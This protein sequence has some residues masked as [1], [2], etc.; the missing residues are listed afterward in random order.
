MRR[1]TEEMSESGIW[2]PATNGSWRLL[3]LSVL[4]SPVIVHAKVM[5]VSSTRQGEEKRPEAGSWQREETIHVNSTPQFARDTRKHFRVW[6]KRSSRFAARTVLCHFARWSSSQTHFMS[7]AQCTWLHRI[8]LPLPHCTPSSLCPAE[9][10]I[11]HDPQHGVQFGRFAEQC[12]MTVYEPNDSVEVDSTEVTTV[13]SP[14]RRASIGS[15]YNSGEDIATTPCIIGSG[16]KTNF[17]TAGFTVVDCQV[18]HTFQTSTG[19]LVAMCSHKRK[20]SLDTNVFR[21]LI[22]RARARVL[23]CAS[24]NPRFSSM[25]SRTGRPR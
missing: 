2:L 4:S 22:L 9:R 19:R 5:E 24:G 6:F 3:F 20:S 1:G 16:W 18:H 13:L 7:H 21:S 17:G 15:T 11:R 23:F 8:L 14:P 12:S 10:S 25:A